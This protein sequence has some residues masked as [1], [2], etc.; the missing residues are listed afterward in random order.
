MAQESAQ[1]KFPKDESLR[2]SARELADKAK[3]LADKTEDFL[4]VLANKVTASDVYK[5]AG[6]YMGKAEDYVE[7]KLDELEKSGIREKLKAMADEMK[8]TADNLVEKA[9]VAGKN[10]AD[11]TDEMMNEFRDRDKKEESSPDSGEKNDTNT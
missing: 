8:A 6:E 10:I 3:E 4:R 7:D 2:E 5:K 11:K 9:R 1:E